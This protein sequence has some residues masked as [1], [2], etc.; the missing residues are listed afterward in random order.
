MITTSPS[1]A[2]KAWRGRCGRPLPSIRAQAARCR[3]PRASSAVDVL[4]EAMATYTVHEP[5]RPSGNTIADADRFAFVRDGFYGWAFL[6]GP[7]WMI[8]HR[9]WLVLLIYAAVLVGLQMLLWW[10]GLV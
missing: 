5:P 4:E 10:L 1:R 8:R 6:L 3:P 2:S 7:L 9:L